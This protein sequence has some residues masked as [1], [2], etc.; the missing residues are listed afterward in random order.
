[1]D[2]NK[3]KQDDRKD[4][5]DEQDCVY[6]Y[7]N[8][9]LYESLYIK[10]CRKLY[11]K[12]RFI[13][14]R[15]VFFLK[16]HNII[17]FIFKTIIISTITAVLGG[18]LANLWIDNYNKKVKTQR[19]EEMLDKLAI[20]ISEEYVSSILGVPLIS[21]I[22]DNGMTDCYYVM[23]GII[24]RTL[25]WENILNAYFITI[26]DK[27]R[28]YEVKNRNYNYVLGEDTYDDFSEHVLGIE[29]KISGSGNIHFYGEVRD[30]G[31]RNMFNSPV[32]A[33]MQYGTDFDENPGLLIENAYVAIMKH[34]GDDIDAMDYYIQDTEWIENIL[35]IVD[36]ERRTIR[37]NT[38]GEIG[39]R[40][41][42]NIRILD[43]H[44]S[45]TKITQILNIYK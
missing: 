37:P 22:D 10:I 27:E 19:Q 40:Y 24:V 39:G 6:P 21:H 7:E 32:L 38:Y 11:K 5:K 4:L 31:R 44:S 43:R 17:D 34:Y 41:D 12:R 20:G 8:C 35:G 33:T 3:C 36:E 45:W 29:S 13:L 14:L 23:N 15:F 26:T 2:C 42:M 1:M 18:F 28:T 30:T 16:R 9:F 25:Y